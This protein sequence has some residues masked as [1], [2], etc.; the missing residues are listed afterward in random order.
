L[1][2]TTVA[3]VVP[4]GLRAVKGMPAAMFQEELQ[5]YPEQQL[6]SS[7]TLM[8]QELPSSDVIIEG[9]SLTD[10]DRGE[11]R[12]LVLE[13]FARLF[14]IH[15]G[16]TMQLTVEGKSIDFEVVGIFK[17][18]LILTAPLK[19]SLDCITSITSPTAE[20]VYVQVN[21]P[22]M[23]ISGIRQ[24]FPDCFAMKVEDITPA[25]YE[26][27]DRQFLFL[28]VLSLFSLGAGVVI[29]SS[30]VRM[31]VMERRREL[32]ILKALGFSNVVIS[33]VVIFEK[34][35]VGVLSG[36]VCAVI[37]ATGSYLLVKYLLGEEPSLPYLTVLA[38]LVLAF[39]LTVIASYFPVRSALDEKPLQILRYE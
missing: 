5:K 27:I 30:T 34:C 33:R 20:T 4:V 15:P 13:D 12:V 14:D 16:D 35:I 22:S 2:H 25:L 8:G 39:V 37:V 36:M 26:M 11:F 24:N 19:T 28:S 17:R 18:E 32:G 21:D 10:S 3:E 7:P 23:L 29:V 38:L 1:K 9:R 31:E 6:F